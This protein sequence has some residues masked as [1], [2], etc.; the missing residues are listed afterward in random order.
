MIA[1]TFMQICVEVEN[2][3][4]LSNCTMMEVG[5]YKDQ[6]IDVTIV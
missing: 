5:E 2:W 3:L 4:H 1:N 6:Y